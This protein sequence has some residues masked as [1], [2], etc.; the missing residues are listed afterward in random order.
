M[1]KDWPPAR[2]SVLTSG[3]MTFVAVVRLLSHNSRSC[4]LSLRFRMIAWLRVEF[5]NSRRAVSAA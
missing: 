3:R 2:R 4:G 1:K 5:W